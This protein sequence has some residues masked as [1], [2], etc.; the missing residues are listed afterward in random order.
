MSAKSA[1]RARK[2]KVAPGENPI[3]VYPA[4]CKRCGICMAFCPKNVLEPGPDG[5]PCAARPQDC[6]LCRMCELRCPDFAISVAPQEGAEE[7]P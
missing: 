7:T 4:W 5:S 1:P 3:T 2:P 6:I